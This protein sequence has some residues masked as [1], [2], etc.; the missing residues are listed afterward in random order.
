M[1]ILIAGLLFLTLVGIVS[2]FGYVHYV[3]PTRLL[4]QLATTTSDAIPSSLIERQRKT[5][6]SLAQL[7]EPIG[8]LLPVSSQDALATKHELIQAGIRSRSAVPVYYGAKIVLAVVM[9]ILGLAMRGHV[10]NR[11]LTVV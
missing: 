4:D 1:A 5:H 8:N 7:L 10:S 6:F 2:Y 11:I 3:K 9:V